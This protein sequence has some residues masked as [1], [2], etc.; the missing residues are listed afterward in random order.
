MST[1]KKLTAQQQ[2]LLDYKKKLRERSSLIDFGE[3]VPFPDKTLPATADDPENQVPKSEQGLAMTFRPSQFPDFD[4]DDAASVLMQLEFNGVRVGTTLTGTRPL[5]AAWFDQVLTLPAGHTDKEGEHEVKVF[6]QV[7]FNTFLSPEFVV[8]VDTTAPVVTVVPVVPPEIIQDGITAEFFEKEPF[9]A[10]SHVGTYVDAKI[11]DKVKFCIA[12][13]SAGAPVMGTMRVIEEIVRTTLAIPLKTEKLTKAFVDAD[14]GKRALFIIAED[15]KG[16]IGAPS[17][18]VEVDVSLIPA[19]KSLT[20]AVELHDDDDQVLH[21]DAQTP[22]VAEFNFDNFREGDQL[23]LGLGGQPLGDI[24]VD[25]VPFSLPLTYAQIHLGEVGPAKMELTWQVRRVLK[26]YPA[27]PVIKIIN[28]DLRKP[29]KPVDPLDPGTPGSPDPHLPLVTVR[30][31]DRLE[32]NK[33]NVKD[34]SSGAVAT[35]PIYEGHKA[36]DICQLR[37]YGV[38]VPKADGGVVVLDGSETDDTVLE[39]KIPGALIG[40]GGNKPDVPVDYIVSHP[41]V[42]ET[43]AISRPQPVQV[44]ISPGVMVVPAFVVFGVGPDGKELHCGSLVA[45]PDSP[46]KA[47]E[48]RFSGDARLKDINVDFHLLGYENIKDGTGKNIPG[49]VIVDAIGLVSKE[50]NEAEATNGFSVYFPWEVFDK[51]RNGWCTLHCSA[52]LEGYTTPS[53]P[54]FYRVGMFN[55]GTGDFCPLT[56]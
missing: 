41:S 43:I 37:Y 38:D 28:K 34:I 36:G 8:R 54:E 12:E 2:R 47:V 48:V 55:P 33:L 31:T 7:R 4:L 3:P 39:W 10:L 11:G 26:F 40:D 21:A 30:G 18:F 32:P 45:D 53:V 20:V 51:I 13:I 24:D 50:P 35:A 42:N 5:T 44:Y 16:N 56:R 15:R 17:P 22:V 27:V 19:P 52:K 9:V 25:A 46:S 49:D 23:R 1:L 14:E 6:L 29:G